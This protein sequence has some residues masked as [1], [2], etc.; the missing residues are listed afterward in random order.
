MLLSSLFSTLLVAAAPTAALLPGLLG[1]SGRNDTRPMQHRLAY[2]PNG[3]SVGWSTYSQLPRPIVQ[4]GE[5]PLLLLRVATSN[6]SVT[7][8]TSSVWHNFVN[9]D[10][11]RPNKKYFYRVWGDNT[12]YSFTTAR[13]AGDQAEFSVVGVVDMGTFGPLGLTDHTGT[14]AASPLAPGEVTTIQR[15]QQIKDS[16][17]F[18]IHPGDISYADAWLKE[19]EQGFLTGYNVSDGVQLYEEIN[20]EYFNEFQPIS[21]VKP[22]LV[23][24]GNHEANCINTIYKG[25]PMY[26]E[27][28]CPMGQTNF[29]G[30]INRFRMPGSLGTNGAL[31]NFWYSFNYGSAHFVM[32]DTETD[33]GVGRIGPEELGGSTG[34][35]SGP[36]GKYMNQQL[37]WLKADL[38]SVNRSVTPWIIAAGHRPWYVASAAKSRCWVCQ[39]AFEGLFNQYGV[40]L[41]F[42]GHAHFS[43]R[44]APIANNVT[45]PNE[46]NNPTAPWYIT[47]GAAGHYDGLDTLVSPLPDY[48]RF[49]ND[50]LYT[51]S[52]LTFHNATHL[53]H[54]FISSATGQ[55]IDSATLYKAR[56]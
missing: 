56:S 48:V 26:N 51:F 46:L 35:N 40:D 28:I 27:S 55:S 17:D 47:N 20:E 36:F 34:D 32:Y 30:Y 19:L 37:D 52:K 4:Y 41:V 18:I 1:P 16:Y 43:D 33:L 31:G 44:N 45:D 29:T 42:S 10:N 25:P 15:L 22:Y 38:A 3:M 13:Q 23:A 6:E 11:L 9:L 14:G 54:D 2:R 39:S 5:N 50:T 7:Y 24:P 21:S 49:A 53:T 12:T 8:P